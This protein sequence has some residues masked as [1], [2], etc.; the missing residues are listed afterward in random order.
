MESDI[1]KLVD[2]AVL[3]EKKALENLVACV[4]DRVY[5]LAL[6]MLAHPE[7]AEDAAQEILIKV[8]THLSSFRKESAFMTWVY[9]ISA[10]HLL[11][12]RKRR[13]ELI[14]INFEQCQEQIDKGYADK[15]HPSVS[16]AEQRLIVKELRLNCLQ[17]LL[18]CLDRDLRIAYA[19]GEIFE[20]KSNEGA[21]I[22]D[23]T[24]EAF[25]QRLSRARKLIRKF[26]QKNCGLINSENPCHCTRFAPSAVKTGWI[27]PEKLIFA[28]HERKDQADDFD[29]SY[30][31][32]LNE[33][34][35]ISTLFRSHLDY[36]A[37]ETFIGSIKEMLDSG[38]F[39]LLQ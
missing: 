3:G 8:I 34:N 23:I 18:Q 39:K 2:L 26:M 28:N 22:L 14:E 21:Y 1:E 20:V 25:R 19:L 4:Q 35:R 27:K 16:E 32:E 24:P 36:A 12:T 7:D 30:L 9:R 10:N 11:T 37:P 33:L 29:E 13:A 15:W 17:A 5:K 38:K 6:R 31:H